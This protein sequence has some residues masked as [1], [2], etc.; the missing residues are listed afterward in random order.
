MREFI[1]YT[2]EGYTESPTGEFVENLQVLGFEFGENI[3]NAQKTLM[4]KNQWIL[5]KGFDENKIIGRQI[6][7]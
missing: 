7:G 2:F 3:I 6:A 5:E 4:A 1:F